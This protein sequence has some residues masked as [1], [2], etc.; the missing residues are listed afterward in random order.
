MKILVV[1]VG[2]T[3]VKVLATGHNERVKIPSG[4]E[5][6]PQRMVKEVK[7]AVADWKYDVVSIGYL[8]RTTRDWHRDAHADRSKG[9]RRLQRSARSCCAETYDSGD[10]PSRASPHAGG[11]TTRPVGIPVG[12]T[13]VAAVCR[14]ADAKRSSR[15]AVLF[16]L[17]RV[18]DRASLPSWNAHFC[19]G[20]RSHSAAATAAAAH[21]VAQTF[22]T[23]TPQDGPP[24]VGLV[25][26]AMELRGA[27]NRTP[28]PTRD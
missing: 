25:P 13:F 1:D 24:S 11:I 14:R 21:A 8:N 12:P 28:S 7:K 4:P 22:C 6:T 18:P 5:M 10:S 3:N 23:S 16:T 20:K 9:V 15:G 26:H 27:R 17:Q 19:G 2:G